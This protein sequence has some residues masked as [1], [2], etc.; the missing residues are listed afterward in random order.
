MA[1]LAP[2]MIQALEGTQQTEGRFVL[3]PSLARGGAG[4]V[5]W[6]QELHEHDPDLIVL[7][8]GVWEAG[9]AGL[10]G[11]GVPPGWGARYQHQVVDPFLDVLTGQGAKVLWLGMA[12]V[13]EP[14]DTARF[15]QLNA[16]F[17]R[18]AAERDDVD[19]L[20]GGQYLSGPEGGYADSVASTVTGAP[21]RLRRTDGLHLCPEGVIA[22]G[23][24]VL[25][26]IARQWNVEAVFGWQ[27]GSWR[28]PPLLHAPE[29]CP[30]PV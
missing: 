15:V 18:A 5:I 20:P 12:A 27:Q 10:A 4:R 22:L 2:A 14:A 16:A 3:A 7:L 26:H 23:T 1:E 19:F 17:A 11:A 21:V 28:R 13:R 9:P 6:D 24:P 30:A 25:D 8:V 29:E